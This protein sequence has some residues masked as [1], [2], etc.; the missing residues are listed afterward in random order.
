MLIKFTIS[1]YSYGNTDLKRFFAR[2]NYSSFNFD[3]SSFFT[4]ELR[5]ASAINQYKSPDK[6]IIDTLNVLI[7]TI[8]ST[9]IK[10]YD[11]ET[12]YFLQL[13]KSIKRDVQ[14]KP[15]YN[16][17]RSLSGADQQRVMNLYFSIRDEQMADNLLWYVKQYPKRKII[18]W[19]HNVHVMT[20][21]PGDITKEMWNEKPDAPPAPKSNFENT[22]MGYIIKDSLKSKVFSIAITGNAGEL[23]RINHKDSTKSFRFPVKPSTKPRLLENYLDAAGFQL[24]FVNLKNPSKGGEWLKEKIIIRHSAGDGAEYYWHK[25]AD[26]LFYVRNFAPVNIKD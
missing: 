4:K 23:G 5:K 2:L 11:F 15:L 9:A 19:A 25:A 1:F 3:D 10:P 22:Y 26:A 6:S 14:S 16:T 17:V 20:D 13:L 24:A 8:N 12:G 18:V 7:K 21:Y